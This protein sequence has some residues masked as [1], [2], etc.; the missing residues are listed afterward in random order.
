LQPG[1]A[2]IRHDDPGRRGGE[3]VARIVVGRADQEH[4]PPTGG[5]GAGEAGLG[6]RAADPLPLP[7]GR[8]RERPQQE[9]RALPQPHRPVANR[10]DQ[11][12]TLARDQA[13][14][15]QRLGILTVTVGDLAQSV[16]T[17]RPVQQR[18]DLGAVLRPFVRECQ[19][20]CSSGVRVAGPPARARIRSAD[21]AGG[22]GRTPA[23]SSGP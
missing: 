22:G 8:N 7:L 10:S 21:A 6:Q 2:L 3:T 19:H 4:Q 16:R 9:C 15:A 20:R 18:L 1:W 23:S 12:A 17:E 11:H 5:L 13:Q 14:I